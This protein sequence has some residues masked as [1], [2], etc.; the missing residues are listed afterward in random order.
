MDILAV[1][2]EKLRSG[3]M[4]VEKAKSIAIMVL[5]KLHPPLTLEQIYKIAPTLDDQFTELARAV[6]PVIAAHNKEVS[7]IVADHAGKL[8]ASGKF[9]DALNLIKEAENKQENI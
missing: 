8:I 3:E 2:E 7:K 4:D 5:E 1:I 9:D 6:L